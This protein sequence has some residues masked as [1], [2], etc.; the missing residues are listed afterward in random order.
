VFDHHLTTKGADVGELRRTLAN[1]PIAK[2]VGFAAAVFQRAEVT[3][4]S[5]SLHNM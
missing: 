4:Q 3:D 2:E 1:V 5:D